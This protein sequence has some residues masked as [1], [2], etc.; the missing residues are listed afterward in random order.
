MTGSQF[1]ASI[2]AE[3]DHRTSF[4]SR[5]SPVLVTMA[6]SGPE[7]VK[8]V[9]EQLRRSTAEKNLRAEQKAEAGKLAKKS[10]QVGLTYRLSSEASK[11]TTSIG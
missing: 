2:T 10:D 8:K 11:L 6:S 3:T 7:A 4:S 5:L 1:T 9:I